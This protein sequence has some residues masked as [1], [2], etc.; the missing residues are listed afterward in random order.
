M[1][2]ESQED[3]KTNLSRRTFLKTAAVASGAGVI[4]ACAPRQAA[5]PAPAATTAETS[6]K[7]SWETPPDPIPDSQIKQTKEADIIVIGAGTAGLC[8]ANAA[9]EA[10]AKVIVIAKDPT[11]SAR[12]GSNFAFGSK[13]TKQFN[14]EIDADATMR[15]MLELQTY[16]AR[17]DLWRI[18]V[19][20]SGEA[21]DWLIDKAVAAGLKPVIQSAG[22]GEIRGGTHM[23]LGGPNGQGTS[24]NPQLDV[25]NALIEDGKKNGMEVYFEVKAEQLVKSSDGRVTAVI[26]KEKDGSYTKYVGKKAVV[27]ATGDY[28]ADKEMKARYCPVATNYP[29]MYAPAGSNSG[30][31]HKMAMWVG[32]AMQSTEPHAVMMPG[33]GGG[34]DVNIIKKMK[35]DPKIWKAWDFIQCHGAPFRELQVNADGQRFANEYILGVYNGFQQI[36]QNK[37]TFGICDATLFEHNPVPAPYEGEEPPDPKDALKGLDMASEGDKMFYRADTLAELAGKLGVSADKLQ[38][39]VDRYNKFCENGVDED[40]GKPKDHL[41]PIRTAPFYGMKLNIVLLITLGGLHTNK[42]MQVMDAKENVIPGLYA[43]GTIGGD[44]Y[45]NSYLFRLP[46]NNLGRCITTGY[47]T[48]KFIAQQA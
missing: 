46:G 30:D 8:T 37:D 42:D 17:S 32:A 47:L 23:F 28:A 15:E 20:R 45:A 43:V 34:M 38:A 22:P 1:E 12:G 39:T 10:G 4:S 33:G 6:S 44:F 36:L 35:E 31:G 26:A 2:N 21:M 19:Q 18:Y 40:F 41:F 24:D 25:L 11:A 13:L 48:G 3:R 5:A 29:S 16:R 14:L 7:A 9:A 27:L